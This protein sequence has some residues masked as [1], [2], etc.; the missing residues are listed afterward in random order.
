MKILK[1]FHV[2]AVARETSRLVPLNA[3]PTSNATPLANAVMLIPPAITAYVIRP[4]SAIPVIVLNH[5]FRNFL[6]KFNFI[7]KICLNLRQLV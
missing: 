7:K 6:T 3:M 1:D 2:M 4:V 5:F